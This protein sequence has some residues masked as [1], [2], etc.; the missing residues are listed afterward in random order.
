MLITLTENSWIETGEVKLLEDHNSDVYDFDTLWNLHPEEYGK[1]RIAGEIINTPRWQQAYIR[2]YDF[3]GMFHSALPLP[4][5]FKQFLKWANKLIDGGHYIGPHSDDER[6][7]VAG[8]PILTISLG[9]ERK[10]RL[11]YKY[12][13]DIAQDIIVG[14]LTYLVM[15]GDTQKEFT[16]EIVKVGGNK[17]KKIAPRISVTFR[18]FKELDD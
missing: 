1:V 8:S 7:L 5:K 6:P 9:Q 11:R 15:G 10:F 2:G 18:V 14:D 4:K 16:H 17:G 3:S 13:K 12:T